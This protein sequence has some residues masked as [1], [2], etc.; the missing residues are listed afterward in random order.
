MKKQYKTND[1]IDNY[2]NDLKRLCSKLRNAKNEINESING[3]SKRPRYYKTAS[4]YLEKQL[5]KSSKVLVGIIN[6]QDVANA[7]K[8]KAINSLFDN[9]IKL[10]N[11]LKKTRYIQGKNKRAD[12]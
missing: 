9:S 10:E 6:N 2:K 3:K 8:I 12:I 1:L 11:Y 4:R 7:D 5:L